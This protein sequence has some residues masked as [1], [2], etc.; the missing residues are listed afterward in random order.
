M[1]MEDMLLKALGS[2]VTLQRTSSQMISMVMTHKTDLYFGY[3]S[4]QEVKDIDYSDFS[5]THIPS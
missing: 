1:A 5:P 3:R 4:P 2:Q